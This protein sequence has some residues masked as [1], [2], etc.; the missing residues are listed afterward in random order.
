MPFASVLSAAR[1]APAAP[2]RRRVSAATSIAPCCPPLLLLVAERAPVCV[3]WITAQ[4]VSPAAG[5][6][7]TGR[8]CR[9]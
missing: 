3:S 4:V 7:A 8:A 5:V 2:S 9:V 6:F 1:G